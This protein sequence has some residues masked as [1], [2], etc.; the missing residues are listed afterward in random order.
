M[1][2]LASLDVI[3]FSKKNVIF[4]ADAKS[5]MIFALQTARSAISLVRRTNITAK[6]YHS[7]KANIVEKS[8]LSRAFFMVEARRVELLSENKFTGPSPSAVNLLTFPPPHAG[9]QAYGFS[10][11]MMHDAFK[12][13]RVHVRH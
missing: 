2:Y 12:A 10:S 4:F 8:T 1:I 6:Q 7:P 9:L 3:Y 11:F 5:D 13:L